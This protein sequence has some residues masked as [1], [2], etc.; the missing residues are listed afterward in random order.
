IKQYKSL[1]PGQFP[2]VNLYPG[3]GSIP[4]NSSD[5]IILQLGNGSYADYID[6]YVREINLPYICFDYYP[7]TGVFAGYLE[8][9]DSIA[10]ACKKSGR[11]MW[12][13]IQ[14]GA[15]ESEKNLNAYQIDWQAY[16][17]LAYGA[18]AIMAASYSKGWWD[19][20]TSCVNR[21]GEKN[22]TYGFVKDLFSALHSPFGTEFLNY[23]YLCTVAYGDIE[24]SESRIRPQ[25][26]RQNK[27]E[28]PPDLPDIKITSDKAIVAGYFKNANGYAVMIVNSHN[29]FDGSVI[30]EVKLETD[31][32]L[33]INILNPDKSTESA[34]PLNK[35]SAA[36]IKI[37]SGQ[38]VFITIC[39]C[40]RAKTASR[41]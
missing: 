32:F 39:H 5:E 7:F 10:K 30:A 16:M 31:C 38:G 28:K 20:T 2:F 14:A 11:E 4:K 26:E 9:L 19:E 6:Q 24:S 40:V 36:E 17:C 15:W 35:F 29:P 21:K 25:L 1:S 27:Q 34:I 3:Y 18:K 41:M 23:D 12:D 8:N 33:R 22:E 37:Q 13:I